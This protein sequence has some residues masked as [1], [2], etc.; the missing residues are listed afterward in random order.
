MRPLALVHEFW[1]AG[2]PL[3]LSS[4]CTGLMPFERV[5]LFWAVVACFRELFCFVMHDKRKNMV[6]GV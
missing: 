5:D 6:L 4:A 1:D 3:A 2:V